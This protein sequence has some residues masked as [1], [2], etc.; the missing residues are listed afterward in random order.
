MAVRRLVN[1]TIIINNI[2][3]QPVPNTITIPETFMTIDKKDL[4]SDDIDKFSQ[5]IEAKNDKTN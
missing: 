1:P 2:H 4:A 3:I 5:P